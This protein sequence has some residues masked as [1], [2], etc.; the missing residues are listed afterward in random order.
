MLRVFNS[1]VIDPPQ[2]H[3][4]MSYCILTTHNASFLSAQHSKHSKVHSVII[5]IYIYISVHYVASHIACSAR[6]QWR[7][8]LLRLLDVPLTYKEV[9]VG[10]LWRLLA[11]YLL[12]SVQDPMTSLI[13]FFCSY[14]SF[15]V[16]IDE[17]QSMHAQVPYTFWVDHKNYTSR[18]GY[19]L[20][21]L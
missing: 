12:P 20:M 21:V 2:S 1:L 19:N 9:E 7:L 10:R 4:K 15:H 16:S 8:F 18:V 11:K 17:Q 14:I 6:W 5:I 3:S 13:H